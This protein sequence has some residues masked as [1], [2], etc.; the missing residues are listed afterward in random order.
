M[1][2]IEIEIIKFNSEPSEVPS[3]G[4]S[5]Q[6]ITTCD[7][8]NVL[9]LFE[10]IFG[11][12]TTIENE[13]NVIVEQH[14]I[15]TDNVKINTLLEN[16]NNLHARIDLCF[17]SLT[18]EIETALPGNVPKLH[19]NMINSISTPSNKISTVNPLG[20]TFPFNQSLCNSNDAGSL[21]LAPLLTGFERNTW[22]SLDHLRGKTA[23]N[24]EMILD[25]QSSISLYAH[26]NSANNATQNSALV[27]CNNI[28]NKINLLAEKA[29]VT[30]STDSNNS[31]AKH[32]ISVDN[33]KPS[34]IMSVIT[35][36]S[37]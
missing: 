21:D 9:S 17:D 6:N 15:S 13:K 7:A 2:N 8:P 29:S 3:S 4:V 34:N 22:A 10:K 1:C 31:F 19:N 20:L 5:I 26:L 27:K 28:A 18:Q 23:E 12:L 36:M 33:N 30:I 35:L 32:P 16:L 37:M 14:D 24:N 25:T 11:K